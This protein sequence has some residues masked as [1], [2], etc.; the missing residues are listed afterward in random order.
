MIINHLELPQSPCLLEIKRLSNELASH[1]LYHSVHTLDDVNTYMEHQ[2]W[3]V[4]DFMVLIKSIQMHYLCSSLAWIPPVDSFIGQE[5]Y[6]IL[7]SE[8][9]DIDDTGDKYSSHFE[10]YLRAMSQAGATRE[11]IDRFITALQNGSQIEAALDLAQPP[12]A[13]REFVAV[14]LKIARGPVHGAVAAF[15]LSREGI[16]PDMFTTFLSNLSENKNLSIFKWYL[17]RHVAVDSKYHGPQS[18]RLF[19]N[20]IG[21]DQQ[22][23]TECLEVAR[24]ALVARVIFLDRIFEALPSQKR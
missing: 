9:A 8:E 20:I 18:E 3:C 16:I 10:T 5:I 24:Q 15:C 17:R 2:V 12:E 14:T 13:A 11:A 1:R 7:R 6:S 22:K 23:L 19:E 4:W 21:N